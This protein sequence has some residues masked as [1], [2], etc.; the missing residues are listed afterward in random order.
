MNEIQE[1]KRKREIEYSKFFN[2]E[3]IPKFNQTERLSKRLARL[4]VSSR[5]QVEKM[6]TNGLISVD[7]NIVKSNIPVNDNN[8]IQGDYITAIREAFDKK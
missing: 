1:I 3:D 4:G 8:K 5:R 7:G 6:I 2:L